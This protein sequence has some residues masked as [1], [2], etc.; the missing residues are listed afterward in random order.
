M[1]NLKPAVK[2]GRPARSERPDEERRERRKKPGS[3]THYGMKLHIDKD[4]LDPNYEYRWANDKTGRVQQ[5]HGED[6]DPVKGLE[7]VNNGVGTVPTQFV[8]TTEEG[9][10][11]DAVLMRKHKEWYDADQREKRKPL[12][13]MEAAIRGGVG[14]E[15][16]TEQDLEG[17]AYTPGGVNIIER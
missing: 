7:G 9:K 6:W 8:G 4:K 10:P 3:T 16:N 11:L 17:V 13:E 14:K 12:D 15:K 1:D 2:R 5:L